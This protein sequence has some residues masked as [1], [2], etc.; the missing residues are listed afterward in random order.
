MDKTNHAILLK[1][2]WISG[3]FLFYALKWQGNNDIVIQSPLHPWDWHFCF[4]VTQSTLQPS[5]PFITSTF[6]KIA[7]QF[8]LQT[9][10]NQKS[11]L[12]LQDLFHISELLM[13]SNSLT[14]RFHHP[15]TTKC[16]FVCQET[17]GK[18]FAH[19]AQLLGFSRGHLASWWVFVMVKL[20][21]PGMD[22]SNVWCR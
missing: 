20:E 14:Q 16:F 18:D 9:Q 1:F 5:V 11:K 10:A 13:V 6:T 4:A 17:R 3:L 12:L 15:K 22:I 7:M 21:R 19:Q 2:G 8:L